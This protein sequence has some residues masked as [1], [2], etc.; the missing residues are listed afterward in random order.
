[1]SIAIGKSRKCKAIEH[2]PLF[3]KQSC[4]FLSTPQGPKVFRKVPAT[5]GRFSCHTSDGLVYFDAASTGKE[6][7][8]NWVPYSREKNRLHDRHKTR[9]T[10]AA[11][12]C[13]Y[14]KI[15]VSSDL[16]VPHFD[17]PSDAAGQSGE[18]PDPW[19]DSIIWTTAYKTRPDIE[20][21]RVEQAESAPSKGLWVDATLLSVLNSQAAEN[22]SWF[23]DDLDGLGRWVRDC[24]SDAIAKTRDSQLHGRL[25]WAILEELASKPDKVLR[26]L[27]HELLEDESLD[28]WLMNG[29]AVVI[30]M[31]AM[32]DFR[33]RA[34]EAMRNWLEHMRNDAA[35]FRDHV[36]ECGVGEMVMTFGSFAAPSD[37]DLVSFFALGDW[38]LKVRVNAFDSLRRMSLRYETKRETSQFYNKH[39]EELTRLGHFLAGNFRTSPDDGA[40]FLAWLT[41][42]L[43][44][45]GPEA[46]MIEK[47]LV[48]YPRHVS[49]VRHE[50]KARRAELVSRGGGKIDTQFQARLDKLETVTNSIT[51]K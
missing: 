17:L 14:E 25:R 39:K 31:T 3:E 23:E 29:V 33:A 35:S 46:Q 6:D 30:R 13:D 49:R 43:A 16:T 41:T 36:K 38:K 21:W 34:T 2:I 24:R 1:M 42:I 4:N 50:L 32:E 27:L 19:S 48:D 18:E 44:R 26:T 20:F 7:I 40:L 37:F 51:K 28:P 47:I 5:A 22:K 15:F 10:Q 12:V 8:Q 11:P 9:P 45:S